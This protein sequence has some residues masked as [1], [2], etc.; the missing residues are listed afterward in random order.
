MECTVTTLP[1]P[2]QGILK[3]TF[4]VKHGNNFT[5]LKIVSTTECN[6]LPFGTYLSN[7]KLNS[8]VLSAVPGPMS[9]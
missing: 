3:N 1:V 6:I 8:T 5:V 4:S 9:S 2:L 7:A